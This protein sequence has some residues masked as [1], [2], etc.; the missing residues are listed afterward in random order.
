MFLQW[1]ALTSLAEV[2]ELAGR[3][4]EAQP[5]LARAGEVAAHK[6]YG[7]AAESARVALAGERPERP[8]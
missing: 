8:S 3:E 5:V 4:P 2:L 7:T 6:G 1:F